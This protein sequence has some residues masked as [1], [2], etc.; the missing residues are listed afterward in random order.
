LEY[1]KWLKQGSY[2]FFYRLSTVLLGFINLFI[3]VRI[4]SIEEIGVWVLFITVVSMVELLRNGFIRNP[5]IVYFT[6]TSETEKPSFLL[7]SFI[8]HG[9]IGILTS[10]ALLIFS[11]NLS[12]FWE[13]P[14]L[15]HLFLVYSITSLVLVPFL[16]FEYML[17]SMVQFKGVFWS[18]LLRQGVTTLYLFYVFFVSNQSSLLELGII[19]LLST[20]AACFVSYPFLRNQLLF[21]K[22]L[23]KESLNSLFHFGKYSIGTAVSSTLLR[24][25]DTWMLGKMLTKSSVA[26]YNPAV[27]IANLVEV[28]TVTIVTL[29][30]S[31]VSTK[32]KENGIEGL[33]DVYVKSVSLIL[34]V[35]IPACTLIFFFSETIVLLIFGPKYIE[36]APLLQITVVYMLIVPFIRQFG[37]VTDALKTPRINFGF[38]MIANVANIILNYF[39]IKNFGLIGA[40]YATVIS[41]LLL[42][43]LNQVFLYHVYKINTFS[44]VLYVVTWYKI[45][46]DTAFR[47]LKKMKK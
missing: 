32:L 34:A 24:N 11:S 10:I 39:F 30:F 15:F 25:I 17:E 41:Y 20:C 5:F 6:S 2:S 40:A 16:Q 45:G 28:P 43:L 14:E 26:M 18:N 44:T 33:K 35:M 12:A 1:S 3:M 36:A 38:L 37:T 19:Q 9:V 46:I 7:S 4:F 8:L 31:H 23:N 42:F 29:L 22:S 27:R 13:A 21:S 47:I